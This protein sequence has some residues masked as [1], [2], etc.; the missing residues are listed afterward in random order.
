MSLSYKLRRAKWAAKGFADGGTS[1]F[2]LIGLGFVKTFHV[3]NGF[4]EMHAWAIPSRELVGLPVFVVECQGTRIYEEELAWAF[5]AEADA[6]NGGSGDSKFGL[7]TFLQ[8]SSPY[9]MS[10]YIEFSTQS[11]Q[12]RLEL[13]EIAS[14]TTEVGSCS[15]VVNPWKQNQLGDAT[16]GNQADYIR[17]TTRQTTGRTLELSE[18]VDIIIPVYNGYEYLS[19]LFSSVTRTELPCRFIIIDDCSPDDRVLPVLEA[20]RAA[21]SDRCTLIRNKHNR[22][23]VGSVNAGLA[24]AKG[25]AILVNTDVELPNHWLERLIAPIEADSKIA[26]V[27]PITNSGTICSFP[28]FLENNELP[29]GLNVEEVDSFLRNTAPYYTEVPTGVGF[30]MAMSKHAIQA[31]GTLDE[32]TFGKGYCEENDWCQRAI[33]LGYTN[34]IAE[35]LFVYHKHGGSF[36]SE[37]KQRLNDEHMHLLLEKHP[38]Y[39]KDVAQFC[40]DNPLEGFR[41]NMFARMFFSQLTGHSTLMVTH[42]L[43]GGAAQFYERRKSRLLQEGG[44]V[45]TLFFSPV[46]S[47]YHVVASSPE[48]KTALQYSAQDVSSALAPLYQVDSIEINEVASYPKIQEILHGIEDLKVTSSASLTTYIHDYLPLCPSLNLLTPN[49][50]YCALPTNANACSACYRSHCFHRS[51]FPETIGLYRKTWHSVLSSSDQV[52]CFSESSRILLERIYGELN[53]LYVKP[54]ETIHLAQVDRST[55][56]HNGIRVGILGNLTLHKGSKIVQ[57]LLDAAG[58][59]EDLNIS[60]IQLGINSDNIEHPL[61]TSV[62]EYAREDLPKLV[63]NLEIDVFLLPSIWPETFSFTCSEIIDMELPIACFDLG[64][65]A[66]RVSRYAKGLILEYPNDPN[67]LSQEAPAYLDAIVNHAKKWSLNAL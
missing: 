28:K 38:S 24:L 67:D 65:P 26:S 11:K 21:N 22:G 60:F 7:S 54:H 39:L 2:R 50:A 62:N 23:F 29:L 32:K 35:N 44:N 46:D 13:G 33:E 17:R 52:I 45:I 10:A 31:V 25:H 16:I 8:Y 15:T 40:E 56:A 41:N 58:T 14:T 61:F 12:Y 49:N 37:E 53:N 66:E 63:S 6:Y 20:F 1:D 9:K 36:L 48:N 47:L 30:C 42:L 19:A 51:S 4:I 3:Y 27:T 5:D 57:E 55:Y 18:P 43:G 34:V 64:A 59:V